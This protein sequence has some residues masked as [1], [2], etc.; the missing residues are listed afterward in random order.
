MRT[1]DSIPQAKVARTL[2]GR[3]RSGHKRFSG[4]SSSPKAPVFPR[5]TLHRRGADLLKPVE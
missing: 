3:A 5:K 4:K 2:T 1:A